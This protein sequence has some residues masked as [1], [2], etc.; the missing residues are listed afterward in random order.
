MAVPLYL[1]YEICIWI[2]WSWERKKKKQEAAE[3]AS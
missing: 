1:L 2:A 3:A